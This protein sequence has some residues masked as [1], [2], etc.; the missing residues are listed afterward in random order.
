MPGVRGLLVPDD[1]ARRTLVTR[2]PALSEWLRTGG[3]EQE[4]DQMKTVAVDLHGYPVWEAIE[5]AEG[6]LDTRGLETM[7]L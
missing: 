1:S 5:V 6:E 4:E 3:Q 7:G 2:I